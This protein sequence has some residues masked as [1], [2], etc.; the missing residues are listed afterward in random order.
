VT[1]EEQFGRNLE[2]AFALFDA[3]LDDPSELDLIPDG[4]TVVIMPSSDPELSTANEE[5]LHE[6]RLRHARH[7]NRRRLALSESTLLVYS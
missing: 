7:E 4:R 6:E 2:H 3:I 5:M 1:H